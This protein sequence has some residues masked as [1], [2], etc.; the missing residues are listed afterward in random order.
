[1]CIRDRNVYLSVV[2]E[3]EVLAALEFV[4]SISAPNTS[5]PPELPF[6]SKMEIWKLSLDSC[7]NCSLLSV[8]T[9]RFPP[10]QETIFC[11]LTVTVSGV[12]CTT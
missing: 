8:S 3:G 5:L 9:T 6:K 7:R 12:C 11:F 10:E 4:G 1:M 2:A